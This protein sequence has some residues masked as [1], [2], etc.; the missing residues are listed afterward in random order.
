M[1]LIARGLTPAWWE[2]WSVPNRSRFTRGRVDFA[3][4]QIVAIRIVDTE[5]EAGVFLV[6]HSAS[7]QK[8]FDPRP[9]A[10]GRSATRNLRRKTLPQVVPSCSSAGSR[11]CI[12]LARNLSTHQNT[13]KSPQAA[14][15]WPH[16]GG[17]SD[18][19]SRGGPEHHKNITRTSQ[20]HPY[21]AETNARFKL[22]KWLL[23]I[24]MPAFAGIFVGTGK[25][26][27]YL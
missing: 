7:V 15:P 19:H 22:K 10:S 24:K 5:Y 27:Q 11:G 4:F 13:L 23:I 8:P 2:K 18:R 26:D 17:I 3:L 14:Q 6:G 9:D 1:E 20:E 12:G 25:T 16:T 21:R